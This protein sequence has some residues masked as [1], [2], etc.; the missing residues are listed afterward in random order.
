MARLTLLFL[1]LWGPVLYAQDAMIKIKDR[2]DKVYSVYFHAD[3]EY[4]VI[5]NLVNERGSSLVRE[6]VWSDGFEKPFNL[7]EL[8]AG[9]YT[10]RVRYSDVTFEHSVA[11]GMEAEQLLAE[12]RTEKRKQRK[13]NK[14]KEPERERILISETA[15]D[16][17]IALVDEDISALSIFVYVE[18]SS[19]DFEYYYWEPMA[20]KKE[21]TYDLKRFEGVPLRVE[22]LED[23]KILAEKMIA[24]N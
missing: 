7:Q 9:V 5:M 23:G 18:G 6:K 24:T 2:G 17:H 3:Y 11:V 14:E 10:F 21:Q 16:L 12:A 13:K 22:V 8:P 19:D 1:M 15:E 20:S 4:D